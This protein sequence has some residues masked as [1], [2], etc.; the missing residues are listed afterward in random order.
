MDLILCIQRGV[1]DG[2]KENLEL[3][4]TQAIISSGNNDYNNIPPAS[5]GFLSSQSNNPY[6]HALVFYVSGERLSSNAISSPLTC[7]QCTYV[8]WCLQQA[9]C[10]CTDI[11]VTASGSVLVRTPMPHRCRVTLTAVPLS[12]RQDLQQEFHSG[13]R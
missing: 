1:E 9:Y 8:P 3:V 2:V 6:M 4:A 5:F 11:A 7:T 10:P 12:D 13:Q